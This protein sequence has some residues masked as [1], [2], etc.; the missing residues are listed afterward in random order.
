M[1]AASNIQNIHSTRQQ[2][3]QLISELMVTDE[4]S[5]IPT[6][7]K[8]ISASVSVN[9]REEN[10]LRIPSE[11]EVEDTLHDFKGSCS[12][13]NFGPCEDEAGVN[14][15][16]SPSA[17][18][19]VSDNVSKDVLRPLSPTA[20]DHERA[21]LRHSPSDETMAMDLVDDLPTNLRTTNH[22]S[23]MRSVDAASFY[24]RAPPK[25]N[26]GKRKADPEPEPESCVME[27][28]DDDVSGS[29]VL[30]DTPKYLS[31]CLNSV[32]RSR[33]MLRFCR[34][35]IF[36]FDSLGG[37]HP[38]AIKKLSA[39]LKLEAGDKKK[40]MNP[41]SAEGKVA[42]VSYLFSNK[43]I[44]F[45]IAFFRCRSNLISVTVVYTCYIL[46]KLS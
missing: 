2:T 3:R 39:Y 15:G 9:D 27:I 8:P 38:Q 45:L 12:I 10:E 30:G 31:L 17:L 1:P 21:L 46:L 43:S 34:T 26:K 35:Y 42:L 37:R 22:V 29:S 6:A 19:Y 13:S 4:P 24:Q 14:G 41:S 33:L 36:T 28:D 18:S 32:G 23:E 25:R 11:A 16:R 40:V 7:S 20:S 44:F 5:V